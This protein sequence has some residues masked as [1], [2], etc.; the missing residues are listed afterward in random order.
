MSR[1]NLVWHTEEVT[2]APGDDRYHHGDLHNQLRLVAAEVI[3]ERGAAGFSLREVARRAGVSHAAPAHHYG[4]AT[5]LLTAV[6]V[7]AFVHIHGAIVRATEGITDPVDRLVAG[8]RA[9]VDV[10][11]SNPGHCAVAF[12]HD[13]VNAEDESYR[14][15]SEIAYDDLRSVIRE[16]AADVNPGLDIELSTRLAWSAMQGLVVLHRSMAGLDDRTPSDPSNA[17]NG[18]TIGDV[19]EQ[20][21]RLLVDGFRTAD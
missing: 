13:L 15:T 18:P 9:Y 2:P 6:A 8:A 1:L 7:D 17:D 19:A 12:R 3:S 10:S 5:G 14:E 20:F 11:L 16:V 21:A 4:D